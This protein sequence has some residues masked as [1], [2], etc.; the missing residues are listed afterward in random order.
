MEFPARKMAA[1]TCEVVKKRAWWFILCLRAKVR[2]RLQE[3]GERVEKLR[4]VDWAQ[5]A[6]AISHEDYNWLTPNLIGWLGEDRRR[7]P[8]R[9]QRSN[10]PSKQHRGLLQSLH[11]ERVDASVMELKP[12]RVLGYLPPSISE[13]EIVL[14]RRI[15]FALSQLHWLLF[16]VDRI[17]SQN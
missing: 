1:E 7:L 12:N 16:L 5:K 4:P 9:R 17:S 11:T 2:C 10:L 15:R 6:R 3:F 13:A 14:T 8:L